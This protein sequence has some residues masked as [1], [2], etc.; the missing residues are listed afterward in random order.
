MRTRLT[1]AVTTDPEEARALAQR[2]ITA[3]CAGNIDAA[4]ALYHEDALAWRN[5]D[6][7]A[8]PK[9]KVAKLLAALTTSVR[10]LR[11][12]DVRITTTATGFVQQ[13][14]LCGL[15]PSGAPLRVPACLVATLKGGL[16]VR[17][18][19]YFDSAAMAP[20]FAAR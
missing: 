16:I 11:Y 14:T 18:D 19:E 3:V 17:L 13:H 6:E 20:L 1:A 8:L 15:A 5:A 9:A 12:E 2:L 7:R 4:L 10:E